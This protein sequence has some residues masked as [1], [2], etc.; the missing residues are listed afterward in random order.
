MSAIIMLRLTG[1]DGEPIWVNP[2][3]VAY[4]TPKERGAKIVLAAGASVDVKEGA[5]GI[6]KA[7]LHSDSVVPA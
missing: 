5:E 7:L 1:A 4:L 3:L 6:V 2:S